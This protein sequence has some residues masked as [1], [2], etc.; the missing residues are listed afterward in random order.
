MSVRSR[1]CGETFQ[2]I[3]GDLWILASDQVNIDSKQSWEKPFEEI[4]DQAADAVGF[5]NDT[6]HIGGTDISGAVFADVDSLRLGDEKS[7]WD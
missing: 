3:E 1:H 7:K 4:K 5:S 6:K 2:R